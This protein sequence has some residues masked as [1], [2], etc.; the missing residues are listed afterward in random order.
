[1]TVAAKEAFKER[2]VKGSFSRK[3]IGL[4]LCTILLTHGYLAKAP[5]QQHKAIT[6]DTVPPAITYKETDDIPEK[7]RYETFIFVWEKIR[8]DYFDPDFGGVLNSTQAL[9]P[10]GGILQY[11]HSDM[12]TPKGRRIEG[13]GIVPDIP[14]EILRKD[15]L[16]GKDMVIERAIQVILNK[17]SKVALENSLQL[18]N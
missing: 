3:G 18:G 4:F 10:K 5:C 8:D 11:P 15:L 6:Q 7:L 14:V 17:E 16:Q 13:K 9:L 1:M 12:R 2:R